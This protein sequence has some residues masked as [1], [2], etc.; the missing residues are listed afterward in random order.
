LHASTGIL[1]NHESPLRPQ[2]FVTQK[3]ICAAR[4]IANGRQTK[5]KLGRL[6]VARDWGWAPE[7]VNAMWLMLQRNKP[8]DFVIATG[9]TNSLQ[10]FVQLAFE[11]FDLDWC[12]YVEQ[13]LEFMRPNEIEISIANPAKAKQ[14]LGWTAE[15][16]LKDVVHFMAHSDIT[17]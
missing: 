13:T 10:T 14:L 4:D 9:E 17:L 15:R 11:E 12:N 7:Y 16:K 3:I 5:L 6:D 2:K 1:F 8:D